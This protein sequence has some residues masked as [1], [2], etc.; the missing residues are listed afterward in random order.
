[1]W[2]V[3]PS[4]LGGAAL[5]RLRAADADVVF[6]S[7]LETAVG[8]RAALRVAF[9]WDAQKGAGVRSQESGGAQRPTSNVEHSTFKAQTPG[10]AKPA[11]QNQK[12]EAG[13][14]R[15]LG[16]GVWPLFADARF[17]GPHLAPFLRV[18]DVERINVE[19]VWN[20]LS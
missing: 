19:A 1:V 16:F 6:S 11:T 15:A 14:P 13:V 5:A 20:A 10:N 3:K 4:L 17:D 12:P 2:V 7:A 8:A 9:A 18:T